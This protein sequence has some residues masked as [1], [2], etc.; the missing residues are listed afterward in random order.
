MQEC[1]CSRNAVWV[2]TDKKLNSV[3]SRIYDLT[4][5]LVKCSECQV[6]R[7]MP[8]PDKSLLDKIYSQDYAYKL[9]DAVSAEKVGRAR[10]LMEII[11]R[12]DQGLKL[13][14]F[15]S[16]SGILLYQA[17]LSGYRSE[18]IEISPRAGNALPKDSSSK[19]VQASAEDYLSRSN[20]IDAS[21]VLSHTFEH[22]RNPHKFLSD[23]FQ[24]MKPGM[25]L[26]IV[27]PNCKNRLGIVRSKYWGYWQVPV[28]TYHFTT[29]SLHYWLSGTGFDVVST[30]TRSG[31]FLSKGLFWKNLFGSKVDKNVSP[32]MLRCIS[33]MSRLWLFAYK[34]GSSDLI[35]LA[36]KPVK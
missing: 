18:G 12:G 24:K 36:K 25:Y 16:G 32:V 34:F 1:P 20:L 6:F 14:E 27:V 9:H 19:L 2:S 29:R 23:L 30:E 22:L 15:G 21:V 31:D 10:S 13:L 28:H 7:T 3:Y 17:Q 26:L 35:V 5:S 11:R 33:T 8:F 4:F